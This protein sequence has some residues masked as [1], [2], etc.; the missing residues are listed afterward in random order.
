[1]SKQLAF[2]ASLGLALYR[3]IVRN[4]HIPEVHELAK[5]LSRSQN[6]IRAALRRLA[7]AHVLVLQEDS[8]E[9]LRAA[10]F[11]AAPTPFPVRSGKH[12]W[13]GS[14]IWDALGIPAL[15]HRDAQITTACACC[16]SLMTLNVK[17]GRVL[18][19]PGIIHFAV[20]ARRW[21]EDL[22]FT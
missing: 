20:P 16:D 14:C 8:S 15:L 3:F 6:S 2:D 22:I 12:S 1:M 4:G 5:A 17:N 9:I 21:Y 13:W 7:N 18:P 11:W 10:P 19:A